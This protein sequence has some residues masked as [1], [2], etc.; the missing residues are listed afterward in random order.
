MRNFPALW[1]HACETG[2]CPCAS[3]HYLQQCSSAL[4]ILKPSMAFKIPLL[5]SL[6]LTKGYFHDIPNFRWADVTDKDEIG[7][8]SFGSVM[9]GNYIPEK[10]TVVVKRFFGEGDSNLKI[11][12][13]EAKMLQNLRHPKV[14]EF[15][16]VCPKPVAIMME[17]ECFDFLPFGLDVQVSDLLDL[18][19]CLDRIQTVEAFKH[20]L[21]RFPKAAIDIAEGLHS[22][23]LHSRN[24]VHRD[25]KPGNVLVSNK[26]PSKSPK[27]KMASGNTLLFRNK[28]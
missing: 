25:L 12:A 24:V 21:P 6:S 4:L 18:L 1:G 2:V 5:D 19:N 3:K 20:F 23:F 15:V 11:V 16:A 28:S 27:S 26:Q 9:K 7:K 17:Y 14:A 10:K 13:K 8:G 22:E